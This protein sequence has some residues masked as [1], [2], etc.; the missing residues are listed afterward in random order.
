M[1]SEEKNGTGRAESDQLIVVRS[2]LADL[3]I[4]EALARRTF[5]RWAGL[6][7]FWLGAATAYAVTRLGAGGFAIGGL[8][9]LVFVAPSC[10]VLWLGFDDARTA[11]VLRQRDLE[12]LLGRDAP[13]K[14]LA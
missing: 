7:F 4:A 1:L 3:E 14:E 9:A 5:K 8:A 13:P 12:A 2:E 11:R 10:F 6:N